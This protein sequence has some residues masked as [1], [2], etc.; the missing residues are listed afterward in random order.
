VKDKRT[1]QRGIFLLI[2]FALLSYIFTSMT[3]WTTDGKYL[4]VSRYLRINQH[5]RV[6]SGE[7]F[8]PDQ[9]RFGSY[10]LVENFFKYFPIKWLDENSEELSSMLLSADYW[11][12]EKKSMVDAYFPLDERE[13][14]VS[15]AEKAIAE[16]VD[17]VAGNSILLSNALKAMVAG[18]KWQEYITD[19]ATAALLIG[20]RL[21]ED[22]KA[23]LDPSSEANRILNGHI[24]ARFFFNLL[25][26]L[27]LY[28]FCRI[29]SSPV[30]S[31]L[32]VV[33][34]QAIMPLTTMYFGWET[35]H[36]L[37]LFVGGLLVIARK[38]RFFHLCL[39]IMLG[40]LFR[41][42][43][44]VFLPLI[45]LLYNFRGDISGKIKLRL[46][47]KS[48]IAGSIPVLLMYIFGTVLF[49]DAKYSVDLIQLGY[50][51][52]Y[53]WSWI[54]PLVF[55]FIPLLFVREIR[56]IDFFKRTWFWVLPFVAMNFVVAR[57]AEVR[58]F[59]PVL[60]FMTPLVGVGLLRLLAS[61]TIGSV[62][63][64]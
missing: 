30:A 52:G 46:M 7:N 24:T 5:D 29:F 19:P 35:F 20:E 33:S 12:S 34:F 41:A 57:T 23:A 32:S 54:Y 38:G 14:L 16:F 3:V 8:A 9:Y 40:S 11:T 17:S 28:A 18:L 55:L 25:T 56:D 27:L 48:F 43:H 47:L 6:V 37:A 59:T 50:N 64:E 10:Y 36:G 53:F 4:L 31:L 44:M 61:E 2:I 62:E 63:A 13:S 42:D 60:A 22:V 49:P 58:L 51:I 26:L 1:I 21:P 39:L 45:Y 15:D